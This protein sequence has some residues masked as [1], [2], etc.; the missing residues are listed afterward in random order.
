MRLERYEART[1]PTMTALAVLFLVVYGAPVIWTELPSW[2]TRAATTANLV[3][4]VVFAADLA[5][6]LW[7]APRRV[8][9][10][11]RHPIDVLTVV[12]PLLR[13]LRILRVFTAGHSLLTRRGGLLRT[14]QAVLLSAGVL[15]TVGALA[16][17]DAEQGA[18]DALIVSFPDALWWAMTTVTTVGYGDL[19]PVTQ[20]GRIVAASLMVVGISVLGV[21]TA[22]VAAWFVSAT[23]HGDEDEAGAGR[24]LTDDEQ[25]AAL[26]E[27]HRAG[28]L[29]LDEVSTAHGRIAAAGDA[30]PGTT[31]AAGAGSGAAGPGTEV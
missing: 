10:L 15:I 14:G 22:S 28:V 18:P 24:A 4:W 5:I 3:I 26:D 27:L 17:L 16:A 21:V 12:L 19:Y 8:R 29:T 2:F 11:V 20:T 9:W 7:L 31:S 6:R 23:D 30:S 25:H 1:S 13:P